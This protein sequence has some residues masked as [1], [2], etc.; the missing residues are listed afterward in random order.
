MKKTKIFFLVLLTVLS[1][2]CTDKKETGSVSGNKLEPKKAVIVA[3][4]DDPQSTKYFNLQNYSYTYGRSEDIRKEHSDTF[5]KFTLDT[6]YKPQIFELFSFGDSTM[7]NTRFVLTPGDSINLSIKNNSLVFSG[8]NQ[9]HYNFFIK[10]DS[11]NSE[12]S[13]NKYSGDIEDYKKKCLAIYNRRKEFLENYI[14]SNNVSNEFT[15]LVKA[16]LKFEYLYNLIIPRSKKSG[17]EGRYV[18][19]ED[20]FTLLSNN[21][22]VTES[23]LFNSKEY[24]DNIQIEDFKDENLIN[25]DYYKRSLISF[26]RFYFINHEH[27]DFSEETFLAE[28]EFIE[29]NFTGK[30]K[31]FAITRLITDYY[32]KGL[33]SDQKSIDLMES[34]IEDYI[35]KINNNSYVEELELIKEKMNIYDSKLPDYVLNEKLLNIHNDTIT[36]K[37]ILNKNANKIKA[38]DFWASWCGPC[39]SE[40]NKVPEFRKKIVKKYNLSWIYI[41]TDTNKE[42]WLAKHNELKSKLS[43]HQYLLINPKKSNITKHLKVAF[44]PRYVVL[45]RENKIA[46]YNSPRP[47]DSLAFKKVLNEIK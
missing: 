37:E 35:D 38:I 47:S 8:V 18:N 17:I 16:E 5:S 39:T 20:I 24:F 22:S 33:G 46:S 3:E 30:I 4:T 14:K 36:L 12:Y 43:N 25:N 9:A 41:S 1:F 11:T 6:I 42:Q 26:L 44:I 27:L 23:K 40:I 31:N 10:L 45:D 2:S 34:V 21:S 19:A 13:T 32:K 28:K 29:K 7:Y 15:K